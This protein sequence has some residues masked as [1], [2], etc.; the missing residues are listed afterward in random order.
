MDEHLMLNAYQ[1]EMLHHVA[2]LS[3]SREVGGWK[4]SCHVSKAGVFAVGWSDRDEILL[5]TPDGYSLHD[6]YSGRKN[7][8]RQGSPY[9]YLTQDNLGV[10]VPERHSSIKIWGVYGGQ[11][12]CVASSGWKLH[13][14]YP[15]WPNSVVGIQ[16]PRE[17][18]NEKDQ[19][20]NIELLQLSYL[21]YVDLKCGFSLSETFFMISNGEGVEVFSERK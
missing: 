4:L 21:D 5:M 3:V 8:E 6:A 18:R 7:I 12:N 19:W 17:L 9:E 16:Y 10:K 15:S 11:G 2:T 13:V 1:K 20:K 14:M